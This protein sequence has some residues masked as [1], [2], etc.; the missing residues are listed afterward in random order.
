[1]ARHHYVPQF[2]LR[3]WATKGMFVAYLIDSASGKVTENAKATVASACQIS[4]LNTYL[5]TNPSQRDFPE[6]GFFTPHVDTPAARALQTMLSRGVSALTPKQRIDWARLLVS[7]AVRTPET[8]REMGP[9]ETKNAF[10]LVEALAKGPPADEQKVTALIQANAQI[11]ERNFPLNIAMEL[12]TDP[13]KLNAI[14][15]MT[16]WIRRWRGSAILI[17]DRPLL[18]FP[19][20]Q[21]PCGIPLDSSNCLIALPIAADAVFFASANAKTRNK[22]RKMTPTK[23]AFAVNEETIW[24]AA[25]VIHASDRSLAA[26]VV[27]RMEGKAKSAWSPRSW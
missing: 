25:G 24:R 5:G 14:D 27:P 13:T 26:F 7:F 18:T 6:T 21:R 4:D 16:W 11:F 15:R 19:R 17:G 9:Q 12:S 22:M 2:L 10:D 8:L 23:I 20:M 1:M 3:R